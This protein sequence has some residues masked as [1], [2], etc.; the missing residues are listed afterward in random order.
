MDSLTKAKRSWNM[1]QIKSTNTGPEVRVRSY[2][3]KRG[4]R[5][6]LHINDLPGKPDIV[7]PKYKTVIFIHGC[8]WHH[9]KGCKYARNPKTNTIFWK[10][11]FETNR[12][13]DIKVKEKLESLGWRVIILWECSIPNIEQE[14]LNAMIAKTI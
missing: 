9:H 3:H 10:L 14:D 12:K 7:L 8:F 13:R 4:F 1:A 2:L 6:R 5:F 11:K